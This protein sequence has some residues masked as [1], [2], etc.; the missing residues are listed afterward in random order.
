MRFVYPST[1]MVHD[2]WVVQQKYGVE[3]TTR[4]GDTTY[5]FNC[6]GRRD[7]RPRCSFDDRARWRPS[8]PSGTRPATIRSTCRAITRRRS[9]TFAKAPT[10]APAAGVR[11]I[12][13]APAP[14]RRRC[15]R[16][17][18]WRSSTPTTPS[19]TWPRVR[20]P[21][22]Y[23]LYFGGRA[24]AN[25]GIPWSEIVGSDWLM[26]NN[27]GIAYG[28]MIEN[29]IGGHGDDRINGNQATN[30]V[31]AATAARTRSSSPTTAARLSGRR[32]RD[33]STTSWSTRSWT[34]S[35][36][37]TGSTSASWASV[38]AHDLSTWRLMRTT[39][40]DRRARARTT[41]RSSS[42][43]KRCGACRLLLRLISASHERKALRGSPG[44]LFFVRR[45]APTNR[46]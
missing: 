42:S 37:S 2:I 27:I 14:I 31:H 19:R 25:E 3:T 20:A 16:R 21:P 6:D 38:Q 46:S 34:S 7:Q 4:T 33:A 39:P 5:G 35:P 32:R 43:A 23:D 44:R 45:A 24:G 17:T 28:A 40:G 36:A 10:A 22:A 11:T 13:P 18:T 9:S 12:R 15:R 29:A 30:H 8:S 41:C 1:P 26:E